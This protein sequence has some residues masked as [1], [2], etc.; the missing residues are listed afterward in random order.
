MN[1]GNSFHRLRSFREKQARRHTHAPM[2]LSHIE[3][4]EQV[5]SFA[6]DV[7]NAISALKNGD[8][9]QVEAELASADIRLRAV[10]NAKVDLCSRSEPGEFLAELRVDYKLCV[11]SFSR[12]LAVEHSSFELKAK[13]D[14]TPI[15]RW[16]YGRRSSNRPNSHVQI[17]A[18]RGALSHILSKLDHDTPHSMES[19]HRPMGGDRFCPCLE[20]IIE[21]LITDCGFTGGP[22]W[23]PT[24]RN[25][26]ANWR[27]IQTRVAV[28]DAPATAA[29]ALEA[30]GYVVTL[31]FYFKEPEPT[32]KL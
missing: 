14:R 25:G 9:V 4:N 28:R 6:S 26:R 11:D 13:V 32:E 8:A 27:R 22:N 23:R 31:P 7:S 12:W 19:L 17:T 21:F 15:I 16:D 1:C 5:T 18:H 29:A 30:M 10:V 2:P 3:F 20:D 24:V